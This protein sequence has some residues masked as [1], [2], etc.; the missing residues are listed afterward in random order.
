MSR[1]TKIWSLFLVTLMTSSVAMWAQEAAAGGEAAPVVRKT[2]G[3]Y[4][5]IFGQG[6]GDMLAWFAM[7]F[8]SM[9]VV[10]LIVDGILTLKR[11]KLM[12]PELIEG[13]RAAL[14]NGDLG[15]ATHICETNPS[16]L[17]RI[18]LTGFSNIQEGYEVIQ[19]SITHSAEYETEKMLQRINYLNICGQL[20]PM[21]GLVGTVLGMIHAFS[22]LGSSS[23]AQKSAMLAA[24][25]GTAMH[26]TV[27]GLIIAI[28][29][30]LSFVI[31]K[32]YATR[33]ILEMQHTVLDL[34]KVLRTAEVDEQ[35]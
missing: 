14:A 5:M 35:G 9:A 26:A 12:P 29:A 28:P 2:G 8:T 21:E 7:I 30:L 4:N 13:V 27:V 6:V 23:G 22:A 11:E 15:A 1:W 24:A 18:L 10:A 16:P 17:S 25:I 34:I 31:L 20:G 33:L 19:E 32:N 3:M